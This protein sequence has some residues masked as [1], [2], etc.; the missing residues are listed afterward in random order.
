M[1]Y[2]AHAFL[3]FGYPELLVGNMISDFVKGRKKDDYPYKIKQGIVL[4]RA[5][6]QF[7][8]DHPV[9]RLAKT[10]FKPAVGLYSGAFVDVAYDHFLANDPAQFQE[11]L[12]AKFALH[13][14]DTLE[15]FEH[16]VPPTFR[17]MLPYM[18]QQ[19][20]LFNY[21]TVDGLESSFAGVARRARYLETSRHVFYLFKEHY[22]ALQKCYID[23]F[24][25]L[26][27][28]T[29]QQLKDWNIH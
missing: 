22:D 3:S 17:L 5:I 29:V 2:L 11:P 13:T 1:N 12:L 4:H 10:Y 21:R 19:N 9:T 26:K 25:S 28:F 16:L 24:P 15:Q 27:D 7:T 14:Y 23:F 18:R 8:D 6:D 20:W